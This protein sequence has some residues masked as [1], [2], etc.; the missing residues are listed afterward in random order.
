MRVLYILLF[1]LVI[2]GVISCKSD[3]KEKSDTSH[4][5][6]Y[7]EDYEQPE[8][9]WGFINFLGQWEV[10]PEFDDVRDFS[11]GRAAVNKKG[12][13]GY[14]S[15][16]GE[17]I[18]P[19][20][21]RNARSFSDSRAI[22]QTMELE[23][24]VIDREG[25]IILKSD[26]DR[27]YPFR[28]GLAM[29][30]SQGLYG[31]IDTS[32]HIAIQNI[33]EK[34]QSFQDEITIAIFNGKYGVLDLKGEWVIDPEW[35]QIKKSSYGLFQL[36]KDDLVVVKSLEKG[37]KKQY[38]NVKIHDTS[39]ERLVVKEKEGYILKDFDENPVSQI[40]DIIYYA[41]PGVWIF[42]DGNFFGIMDY[43]G[44]ILTSSKYESIYPYKDGRALM[45]KNS[46]WGYLDTQGQEIIS[47][48]FPLAWDFHHGFA[49]VIHSY[50]IGYIDKNGNM[51]IP[52]VFIEIKDFNENL[53]AAQNFM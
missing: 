46:K 51:V 28:N 25:N 50:R 42:Q 47:P 5:E 8:F 9:L 1:I 26:F 53:A 6:K 17:I 11:E 22:V 20:Q 16:S 19:P 3:E 38:K 33:Y 31:F 23:Y 4:T 7:F 45:L 39:L 12:Y 21:F 10:K 27:I 35:D 2:M 29:F 44:N 36:Y 49:R 37:F 48:L 40:F 15:R 30:I 24:W 13:W 32:G 52:P 18:I 41:A 14:I 43:D 34:V